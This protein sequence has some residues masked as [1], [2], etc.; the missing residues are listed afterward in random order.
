MPSAGNWI[1]GFRTVDSGG[2]ACLFMDNFE[3]VRVA[4]PT[5]EETFKIPNG[6]F[7]RLVRP[8]TD[9]SLY[10]PY[11]HGRFCTLNEVEGWTLSVMNPDVHYGTRLTNGVSTPRTQRPSCSTSRR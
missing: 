6:N 9:I 11:V 8:T 3:M 2:D 10:H 5:T 4:E 7:D 1:L